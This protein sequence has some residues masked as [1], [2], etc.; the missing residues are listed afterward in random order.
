LIPRRRAARVDRWRV[1]VLVPSV[2][3]II[4]Y[5][6]E[7]WHRGKQDTD[8]RETRELM[9]S[10]YLIA[11]IRENDLPHLDMAHPF[12]LQVSSRPSVVRLADTVHVLIHWAKD[13]GPAALPGAQALPGPGPRLRLVKG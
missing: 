8:A 2:N 7:Y 5:D 12:L 1:D 6:G 10:G 13:A 11:R 4:E 9:H 3:L